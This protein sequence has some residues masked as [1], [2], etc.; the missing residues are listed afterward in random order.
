MKLTDEEVETL[1]E[2]MHRGFR[3]IRGLAPPWGNV[4]SE[5]RKKVIEG[6]RR[7]YDDDSR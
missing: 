4:H 5:Y 2:A 3:G 7:I 1:A 6:I